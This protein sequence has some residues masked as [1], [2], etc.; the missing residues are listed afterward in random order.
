MSETQPPSQLP[1]EAFRAQYIR[2]Q[3]EGVTR[4]LHEYLKM[5]PGDEK[6]IAREWLALEESTTQGTPREKGSP[7]I[8]SDQVGPY[9]LMKEIGRGGQGIVYLAEDPRL[10]RKIALKILQGLGPGSDEIRRRFQ[11]GAEVASRL[12][13]PLICTVYEANLWGD[14]PY[15]AMQYVDGESLAAKINEAMDNQI[16]DTFS[17]ISLGDIASDDI[18]TVGAGADPGS[19]PSDSSARPATTETIRQARGAILAVVELM[20]S[21]CR[22]LHAGHEAGVVHRD[23]KPGNIMVTTEGQPV[24]MDFDMSTDNH[25]REWKLTQLGDVFGTP[26]YMAPEAISGGGASLDRRADVWALGVT[27]FQCITLQ[28]PFL[29]TTREGL[30]Q[31]IL[32]RNPPKLRDLQ[33]DCPEDLQVVIEK[34]LEKRPGLR[35]ATALELAEDLRRVREHQPILARPVT[36]WTRAL[37]WSRRNPLAVLCLILGTALSFCITLLILR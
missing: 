2:N 16:G 28:R 6:G 18:E 35:Y 36:A 19:T 29:A 32:S 9:R 37:R 15:I 10:G 34:A 13:H 14:V 33:P 12:H 1:R 22:T 5:F 25:P 31:A 30:Y 23:I 8:R 20:E 24:I 26:A 21:A 3:R 11:Q 4:R 7:T 17:C 27:L